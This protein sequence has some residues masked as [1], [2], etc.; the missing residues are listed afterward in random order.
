L[1][2]AYIPASLGGHTSTSKDVVPFW[3]V[4]DDAWRSF[5]LVSV[6]EFRDAKGNLIYRA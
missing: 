1:L 4:A 3:S 5:R 2:A 6:E